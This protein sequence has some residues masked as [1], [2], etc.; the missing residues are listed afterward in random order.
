MSTYISHTC[1]IVIWLISLLLVEIGLQIG[2]IIGFGINFGVEKNVSVLN[3]PYYAVHAHAKLSGRL[4]R[5]ETISGSSPSLSN[6]F[7]QP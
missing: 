5:Q 6:L 3:L 4:P 7:P 1:C 2:K